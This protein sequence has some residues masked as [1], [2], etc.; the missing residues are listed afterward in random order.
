MFAH[1]YL[2]SQLAR[3]R[4]RDMLAQAERQRLAAKFRDTARASRRAQSGTRPMTRSPLRSLRA[5]PRA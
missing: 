5:L 4:Q 1:P 3:E 2:S